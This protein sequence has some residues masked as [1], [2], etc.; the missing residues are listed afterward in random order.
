M[1]IPKIKLLLLISPLMF[2]IVMAAFPTVFEV[3][4][5][6]YRKILYLIAI[7][8]A[9]TVLGIWSWGK[10]IEP[11]WMKLNLSE[12]V[13]LLG[14][15]IFFGILLV[16]MVPINFDHFYNYFL[17]FHTLEI[18]PVFK[19][20]D[21][22]ELLSFN[23][24]WG[25]LPAGK[26]QLPFTWK[27]KPGDNAVLSFIPESESH[28]IRVIWDGKAQIIDLSS[29]IKKTRILVKDDFE[30][31][32]YHELIYTIFL[33]I[34]LLTT[35]LWGTIT[36]FSIQALPG[37]KNRVK[38]YWLALPMLS[39]W[40]VYLLTFWPGL[41]SY[42]TMQQW[43]EAQSGIFTDAHPAIDTMFIALVSRVFPTPAAIAAIQ[44]LALA[45][46]TAWGLAELNTRG[47]PAWAT[48]GLSFA[49]ALLPVNSLMVIT[50]WKDILYGCAIF[51]VFIQ[52]I[53][54]VL[55]HGN[56]LENKR[57]LAGLILAGSAAS[58][59]RHNGYPVII[60]SLLVL[61]LPYPKQWLK[62]LMPIIIISAI[63]FFVRVPFYNF[64][65]VKKYPAFINIL[66]LDHIGAHI[67]GK[68]PIDKDD[69]IYL[70]NLIPLDKWNYVC[71]NSEIRNMDGPIPFDFFTIPDPR[72]AQIAIKLFLK[73]PLIDLR[74]TLCASG[75]IWQVNPGY[76][77][78]TLP[79]SGRNYG[80]PNEF[81]ITD[82]PILP[83]L[84]YV[85]PVPPSDDP[86]MW[87]PAFYLLILLFCLPILALRSRTRTV[88][89]ILVPIIFQTVVMILVNYANDFRYMFSTELSALLAL[90]LL[91]L[92]LLEQGKTAEN[93]SGINL[94]HD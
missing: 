58:F 31:P 41:S 44:I 89:L 19:Q 70:D 76:P 50:V 22:A 3:E 34:A 8:I 24:E 5:P 33:I 84:L 68:T 45:F 6:G 92:P 82:S 29:G 17:P 4:H 9:L 79:M 64:M 52:F 86:I 54:I 28:L 40:I 61:L 26:L 51:A 69:L 36:L 37:S 71:H 72:P 42:D 30:R 13:K 66:L 2:A 43:R 23:V 93:Q 87:K 88:L 90:G 14:F 80:I 16:I 57:N 83:S 10:I 7:W 15:S 55:S 46:V 85:L 78:Y 35:L 56:W 81:G 49:F 12:Q 18:Q 53:K 94:E 25:S 27:G 48:W 32:F 74:H 47:L 63:Y 20:Q 59:L 1:K 65:N 39:V 77:I 21:S 91:F 11:T 62:I 38:Y 73:N 67:K 60:V 75:L